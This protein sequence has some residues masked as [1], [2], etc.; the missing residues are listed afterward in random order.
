MILRL[1][2]AALCATVA[3]LPT[4]ILLLLANS[5]RS[6]RILVGS[7]PRSDLLSLC[8]VKTLAPDLAGMLSQ[9]VG[10]LASLDQAS[11]GNNTF[12]QEA[13]AAGWF[14]AYQSHCG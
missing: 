7:V 6:V 2:S 5:S 4:P 12:A 10:D 13:R 1:H 14:L 9:L 3:A 11:L 8:S